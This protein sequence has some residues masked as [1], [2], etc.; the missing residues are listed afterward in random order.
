MRLLAISPGASVSTIDIYTGMT[1]ALR[2]LGHEVMEYHLD[3]RIETAGAWLSYLYRRSQ[4]LGAAVAKPNAYDIS[5]WAGFPSIEMA[6]R[7]Q[8]EAVLVFSGMYLLKYFMQLLHNTHLP[9]VLLLSEDPYDTEASAELVPHAD[10]VFTNERTVL[11][12]LRERNPHTYYLPHAYN[13]A[14]HYPGS[15]D[16]D[17]HV[18][19]HDVVFVGTGF[20][21]RLELLSAVDWTGIDLGLYGSYTLLGSRS[22][23]RQYIRGEYVDNTYAAA[24]YRRANIGLNLHRTSVGFG[25]G[26]PKIDHAESLNP[27]G[28]ELGACGCFHLSDARS[29]VAE[30]YGPLVPTFR[31]ARELEALV[32]QYLADSTGRERY[33][34]QLPAAIARHTFTERANM[35]LSVLERAL[36]VPPE[37]AAALV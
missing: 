24:L 23:L 17:E 20:E 13:P 10:I 5:Y 8:P 19:S 36:A 33:A 31:D 27:R 11:P 29:E 14:V 15:R 28:Y 12:R 3:Q 21:E 22:K 30:V 16:G 1:A 2:D 4:R 18:P 32:R 26:V 37:A 7:H 34:A 25:R 35:V 6:L 9:I